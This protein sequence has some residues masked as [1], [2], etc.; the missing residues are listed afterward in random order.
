MKIAFCTTD[1]E[2]VNQHFGRAD[3]V[4]I[5]DIDDKEYSLA[6]VREFIP[7]DPDNPEHKVDT[8]TKA[9]ALRDCAILYV[10]EIG[11]PAA[12]HVIKNRIH[13]VKVT[14]PVQITEVLDN[15]KTTLAGNPAPWLKKAMLKA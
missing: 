14:E 6:E 10:A 13:P 3:K 4:A 11:G 1:M 2:T 9:E 15:L 12:A 7:V 8:E 5:Y